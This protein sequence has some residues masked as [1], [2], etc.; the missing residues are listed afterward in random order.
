MVEER[1]EK[2]EKEIQTI[3]T[4]IKPL[5]NTAMEEGFNRIE[6]LITAKLHQFADMAQPAQGKSAAG[7]T[8]PTDDGRL[9]SPKRTKFVSPPKNQAVPLPKTTQHMPEPT[10]VPGAN[11]TQ[12][13]ETAP[14]ECKRTIPD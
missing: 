12:P 7:T 5:V 9:N 13:P 11:G 14:V 6:Q 8:P 10:H 3:Q 1:F 2:V 4:N